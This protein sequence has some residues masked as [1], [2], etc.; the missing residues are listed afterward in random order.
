MQRARSPGDRADQVA[1]RGNLGIGQEHGG[2]DASA[3]AD[4]RAV[5]DHAR[6]VDPNARA[7]LDV[8]PDQDSAVD[9]ASAGRPALLGAQGV[10]ARLA[11][12]GARL[13]QLA[14]P[15]DVDETVRDVQV[16]LEVLGR[17]ADVVP[18]AVRLVDV[19]RDVAVE[20][21]R[22]HVE[23]EVGRL[24]V[25]EVVEDLRAQ[26][27]DH[28]V[29][30]VGERLRG[31]RLLLKALNAP[32]RAGH[33]HAVLLRVGDLLHRERREAVVCRVRG[34]ERGEVDVGERVAG[35]DE[36]GLVAEEVAH[37]ATPPAVLSSSSSCE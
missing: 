15:L 27:V 7:D 23:R 29:R 2:L 24:H 21:R 9:L 16:A 8:A 31:V 30:Q 35:H 14:G 6:A 1:A 13:D 37:V 11:G 18:V 36:E 5:A 26:R 10:L 22:E 12:I 17:R 19:E 33:D 25:G 4:P 20:E 34:G 28:A 32:V 3:V